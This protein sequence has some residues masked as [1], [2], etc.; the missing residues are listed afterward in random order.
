MNNKVLQNRGFTLI[1]MMITVAL[2]GIIA[3]VA[4]PSYERYQRKAEISGAAAQLVAMADRISEYRVKYGRYPNDSH[5]VPP[6]GVDMPA[7]WSQT[8]PLGGSWNWE[9][10]NNYAYAGISIYQHTASLAE[11][12]ILDA[13]LDDGN[14]RTGLFRWGSNSRPVY[15]IEDG[16]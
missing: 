16:I 2:I 11:L 15:I 10:P 5:I 8:T 12:E 14:M 4:L 9:G 6:P 1:E 13:M 3:A 7:Y